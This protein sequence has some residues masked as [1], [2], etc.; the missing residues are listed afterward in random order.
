MRLAR[1]LRHERDNHGLTLS[2][3]SVLGSLYRYGAKTPSE[4]AAQER[5][6][7]PSMTRIVSVLEEHGL[8]VRS[9]DP[10]R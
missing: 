1:R 2:Q 3:M 7:P 6:K 10:R 8:V 9:P 4:L 5:V